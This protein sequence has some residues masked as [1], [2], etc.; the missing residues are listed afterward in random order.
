VRGR[1]PALTPR[2]SEGVFDRS[3]KGLP[4][5]LAILTSDACCIEAC[6]EQ[7]EQILIRRRRVINRAEARDNLAAQSRAMQEVETHAFQNVATRAEAIAA[8]SR[9][10]GQGL[11]DPTLCHPSPAP[12]A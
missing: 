4:A 2:E 1:H 12:I 7:V 10:G 8:L 3:E 11:I 5:G 9:K 6:A